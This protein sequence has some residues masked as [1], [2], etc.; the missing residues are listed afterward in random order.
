M[1]KK[2]ITFVFCLFCLFSASTTAQAQNL[3][4]AFKGASPLDATATYANYDTS[5]TDILPLFSKII[6][7]GLSFLGVIFLALTIYGGFLWMS[8]QG[9]EEQVAK[10]K[11]MIT[12][13]AIGLIIVLSSYAVSWFVFNVLI[14]ATQ[15]AAE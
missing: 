2:K 1:I 14:R 8:D 6:G 11:K 4:N 5:K 10:A 12:A 7:I 13:A 3:N 9:N 15:K